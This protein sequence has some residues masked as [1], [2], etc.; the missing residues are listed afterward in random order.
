MARH[1]PDAEEPNPEP[2][3]RALHRMRARSYEV[4]RRPAK[5]PQAVSH[6]NR[7]SVVAPGGRVRLG[8][9]GRTAMVAYRLR[10]LVVGLGAAVLISTAAHADDPFYK[11]KR[12]N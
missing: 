10:A 2:G 5:G 4:D 1:D 12:L 11:G 9:H 3:G 6:L 8:L 7:R